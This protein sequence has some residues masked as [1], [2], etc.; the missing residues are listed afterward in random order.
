MMMMMVEK[1]ERYRR[2]AVLLADLVLELV[3]PQEL[4]RMTKI[5]LVDW[6]CLVTVVREW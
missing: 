4:Y 1:L 5:L 6:E 3:E 2:M